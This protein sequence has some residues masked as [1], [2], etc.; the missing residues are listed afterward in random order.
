MLDKRVLVLP[1]IPLLLSLPLAL[2]SFSFLTD[3]CE[4]ISHSFYAL[5]P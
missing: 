1:S 5:I 3:L 4:M 2:I